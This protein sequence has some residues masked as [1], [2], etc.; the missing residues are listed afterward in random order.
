MSVKQ[1]V[2][3]GH[4]HINKSGGQLEMATIEYPFV[5]TVNPCVATLA[6]TDDGEDWTYN[7]GDSDLVQTF[8]FTQTPACYIETLTLSPSLSWLTIDQ[9]AGT[10]TLPQTY[11]SGI[12]GVHSVTLTSSFD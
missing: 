5:L 9:A 3:N 6:I 11:D 2:S 10:I 8:A 1:H 12:A 4:F 7:L